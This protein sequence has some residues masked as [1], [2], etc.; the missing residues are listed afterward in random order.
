MHFE[1]AKKIL[2]LTDARIKKFGSIGI[3]TNREIHEAIF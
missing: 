1:Q 2:Q 3:S